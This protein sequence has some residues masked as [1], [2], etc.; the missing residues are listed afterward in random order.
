MSYQRQ[1][2][3]LAIKKRIETANGFYSFFVKKESLMD[4]AARTKNYMIEQG[5]A[6]QGDL[7]LLA[8]SGGVDSMC[9]AHILLSLRDKLDIDI[10]IAHFDHQLRPES[11][12]EK[13]F[14]EEFAGRNGILFFPGGC[15]IRALGGN[16]EDTARRERYAFLRS[17][18]ARTGAASIVLAHHADDQAETVLLHLLRGSGTAGLAAMSPKE[19][20]LIRPLLFAERKDILEYAAEHQIEYREDSSNRDIRYSRNRIRHQLMPL[21]AE[22]NPRVTQALNAAAEICRAED[23]L[24]DDMA[25]NALAEA[26]IQDKSALD[27]D[28]FDQ[29]P[30]ALQRRVTRKAF[31]LIKG[32]SKG[33]N[34]VQTE[35]VLQ[36]K[37]ESVAELPGGAKA[38]LRGDICF[39]DEVPPLPVYDQLIPVK[40]DGQWH[41]LADWGWEYQVCA[42]ETEKDGEPFFVVDEAELAALTFRTRRKGDRVFSRGRSGEK[43]LKNIFIEEHIPVYRRASWPLLI[44]NGEIVWAGGLWEKKRKYPEKPVLIKIRCCDTI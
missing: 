3:R 24:L 31:T 13:L 1:E 21:L 8:V 20:G 17:V 30:L 29:M 5:L 6:E 18:A 14:V 41:P 25:E 15:D 43:K 26:W 7:L 22:F 38:Y 39:A 11:A 34:F 28:C 36:L 23:A 32:E 27:K 12:E 2:K 44:A 4:L 42:G 16:I 33:L 37:D 35:S 10:A 40:A 9:L 19:D